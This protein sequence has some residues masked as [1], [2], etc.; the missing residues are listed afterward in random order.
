M[1]NRQVL[2]K[3]RYVLA[4]VVAVAAT[5]IGLVG[6]GIAS[7]QGEHHA[8]PHA[9]RSASDIP[10]LGKVEV[11]IKAYYGDPSGTGVASPT[12]NYA[13]QT[14]RITART[15]HYLRSRLSH[16]ARHG[17][18]ALVLD[19]DDTSLVT[20]GYEISEGFGYTP[21]SNAAYLQSHTLPAVF[22]MTKLANWAASHGITVFWIT[23]RP[24]SQRALTASNLG[25][26]GYAPATDASHLFLKPSSP[27][28]YLT[29]GTT[30]TTIQY[31]SLTRQ[32]IASE[33]F[34]IL[35]DMGDQFSDLK[36]GFADRTVKMPNPMYFIP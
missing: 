4:A 21:A 26:V 36:G 19:I 24:E 9:P 12:S 13:G 35:A 17:K 25:A 33:G 11:R 20:Y 7:A 1:V 22:G 3:R 16:L 18:P 10:N 30:C 14:D 5:S 29:C 28:A 31:K 2:G 34:D 23:G 32:H 27:P 15:R 8:A 6:T